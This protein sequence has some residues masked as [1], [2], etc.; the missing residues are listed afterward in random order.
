[1][2]SLVVL[3]LAGCGP[4]S[5]DVA[6][7]RMTSYGG[8]FDTVFTVVRDTVAKNYQISV[9]DKAH[10]VMTPWT[11]VYRETK[12]TK[13]SAPSHVAWAEESQD[14]VRF[15]V[16]VVGGP[17]WQVVVRGEAASWRGQDARPTVYPE[18]SAPGSRCAR[19][20]VMALHRELERCCHA[21]QGK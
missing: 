7:A 20:L 6:Y 14:L 3:A 18:D 11:A 19:A 2:K 17:P 10:A 13:A 4:S 8:D 1:M 15:R 16:E 5:Q 21:P 9:E 12:S